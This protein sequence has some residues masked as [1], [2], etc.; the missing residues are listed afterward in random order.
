MHKFVFFESGQR[1]LVRPRRWMLTCHLIC[2]LTI[3]QL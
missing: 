1:H 3:I 2:N